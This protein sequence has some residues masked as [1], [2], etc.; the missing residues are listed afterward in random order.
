MWE[1]FHLFLCK[2]GS[3]PTLN[4][5][6]SLHIGDRVLAFAKP[7]Q[8]FSLLTTVFAGEMNLKNTV[9]TKSLVLE[10]LDSI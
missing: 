3:L 4:P 10:S 1:W 8:V 7:S 6:P 2:A 9:Y 5:W